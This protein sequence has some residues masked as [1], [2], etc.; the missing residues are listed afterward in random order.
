MTSTPKATHA[1]SP[2]KVKSVPKVPANWRETYGIIKEMRSRFEAPVDTMGCQRAQ[3]EESDPRNR[4][5]STLVSLMLS[6]QTTDVV[7]FAAMAKLRTALG[8]SISIEA[9]I[10]APAEVISEAIASVGFWRKK[11]VYLQDAAKKLRDEFNSD[12]PNTVDGLCSLPGVGP[13]MAYLTLQIAWNR[14]DGIGVDVHVHRITNLL[15][16]HDPPTKTPEETRRNLE[17]W[18][19]QE[20]YGDINHM[21]VGFGQAS[22]VICV[23]S[24]PRCDVCD[25][26][27]KGLC[28]SARTVTS[29]K[30]KAIVF[31]KVK[32]SPPKVEITLEA[33][34]R[35]FILNP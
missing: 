13:K 19:P 25:L 4:R 24:S 18:L 9:M 3:M 6:S 1:K 11:T 12:V 21:M 8:G 20:L 35:K 17:S 10:A 27:T 15:G 14:Y 34:E 23:S 33:E 32:E 26:S 2:K 7:Q 31:S 5:Y 16:W 28:P 30:R 22:I 29:K